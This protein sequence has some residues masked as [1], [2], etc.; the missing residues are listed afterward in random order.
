MLQGLILS[1][2]L[3]FC[4]VPEQENSLL[5]PYGAIGALQENAYK[6]DITIGLT[7][8]DTLHVFTTIE[9][10][11]TTETYLSY[12]PYRTDYSIGAEVALPLDRLS[13]NSEKSSLEKL[14]IIFGIWR[15]CIHPIVTR[16]NETGYGYSGYETRIYVR[17]EGKARIY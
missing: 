6:Q 7:Y 9:T 5:T 11:D 3:V 2:A 12:V 8:L 16:N 14:K 10:Y 4:Y 15:E 17:V 13:G 1:W